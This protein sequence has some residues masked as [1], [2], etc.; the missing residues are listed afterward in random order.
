MDLME[1]DAAATM[2]TNNPDDETEFHDAADEFPFDDCCDVF[3]DAEPEPEPTETDPSGSVTYPEPE[4]LIENQD[5]HP[6]ATNLRRRRTVSRGASS[7]D[8]PDPSSS[9]S[10]ENGSN[11]SETSMVVSKEM[12]ENESLENLELE[13]N[14]MNETEMPGN[15]DPVEL[16]V[17]SGSVESSLSEER[18]PSSVIPD[19]QYDGLNN[20][21]R[22]DLHTR[23]TDDSNILVILAD[24]VIKAIAFQ[25]NLLISFISLS[26]KLFLFPIRTVYSTYTL[27][28]DPFRVVRCG[29]R[30]LLQKSVRLF[31]YVFGNALSF[32]SEWFKENKSV[33]RFGLKC[34]WGFLWSVY[35]AVVLVGLLVLAFITGGVLLSYLVEEP[36]K[37]V[38]NLNF[39]YTEKSPLAFVP[40]MGCQGVNGLIDFRGQVD[41]GKGYGVHVIPPKHKLQ[42]TIK[43][44]LPESDYNRNLGVF[45][46][47]IDLI[48]SNGMV[49]ASSRRPCMLHFKSLPIRLLL[50]F[51]KAAPLITGYSS[52]S[53]YLD[54]EF[55][56]F[57]EGDMPTSCIR[58]VIEQ[59]AEFHPGGGIPQLYSA[60]LILESELPL[61]KKII[62]Y[63][64]TTLFVWI[65]MTLFT[66]ELLFALLCCK[67][68]VIPRIRLVQ[69]PPTNHASRNNPST[70]G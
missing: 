69:S 42:A 62:W 64:K 28:M 34:G 3:S 6:P 10:L 24:L 16:S 25:V 29:K 9:V 38:E 48:G 1:E 66:V 52:E 32:V 30:Y 33:W 36:I 68:L 57:T 55:K 67:P 59:R 14:K 35:V 26:M 41:A 60:N 20:F 49:L 7:L 63:W 12:K 13:S 50:T 45:Q 23:E 8:A 43:L 37:M 40:I 65:S 39:D 54:I 27:V 70:Q 2:T 46:V 15:L 19:G 22:V 21:Q 61:H 44:T 58:V 11:L 53:Q 18:K 56:G 17:S 5:S 4:V 31:S 51:L 47:R